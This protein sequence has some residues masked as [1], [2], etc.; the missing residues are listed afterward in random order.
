LPACLKNVFTDDDMHVSETLQYIWS[1]KL[2]SD[3]VQFYVL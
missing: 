1:F 2:S 3:E